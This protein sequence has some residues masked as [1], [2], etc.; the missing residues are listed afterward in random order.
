MEVLGVVLAPDTAAKV[1]LSL[2]AIALSVGEDLHRSLGNAVL[3][4]EASLALAYGLARRAARHSVKHKA[5]E[6]EKGAFSRFVTSLKKVD[7][8]GKDNLSIRKSAVFLDV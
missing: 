5:D 4:A 1:A 8:V 3:P 6:G 2:N 7:A